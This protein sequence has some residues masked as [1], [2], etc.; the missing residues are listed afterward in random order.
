MIY[1]NGLIELNKLIKMAEDSS[2]ELYVERGEPP[3][4]WDYLKNGGIWGGGLELIKGVEHLKKLMPEIIE[5]TARICYDFTEDY[6]RKHPWMGQAAKY[7]I[8]TFHFEYS[9]IANY[10]IY[11]RKD[12][13]IPMELVRFDEDFEGSRFVLAWWK[14]TSDGADF[15]SVGDRLFK[16]IEKE[17]LE[18]VW[19]AMGAAQKYLDDKITKEEN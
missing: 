14:R 12:K 17:D 13:D 15:Q 18:V 5:G 16:Y 19:E 7:V 1:P 2:Y 6:Y 10:G 8:P 11:E 4:D 9:G 3:E